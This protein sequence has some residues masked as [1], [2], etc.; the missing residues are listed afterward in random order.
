MRIP[1]P[2]TVLAAAVTI[3]FAVPT[4]TPAT[5]VSAPPTAGQD[6]GLDAD[7]GAHSVYRPSRSWCRY[8]VLTGSRTQVSCVRKD[9]AYWVALDWVCASSW[10]GTTSH[11]SRWSKIQPKPRY[12]VAATI[13]IIKTPCRW[14]RKATDRSVEVS[15]A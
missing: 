3:A 15:K 10:A 7:T 12:G 1:N 4:T 9:E 11:E 5:T 13:L 2:I 6:T 8:D 14:P